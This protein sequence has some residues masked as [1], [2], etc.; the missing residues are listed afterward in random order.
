MYPVLETRHVSRPLLLLQ[1]SLRLAFLSF[2]PPQA[3]VALPWPV[4]ALKASMVCVGPRWFVL[5]LVSV[6]WS[7]LPVV[8]VGRHGSLL[9]CV[10]HH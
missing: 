1:S 4:L 10:D 8:C 2:C 3:Q 7:S 6:R 5:A 9:A